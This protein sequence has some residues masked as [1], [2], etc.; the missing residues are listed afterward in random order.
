MVGVESTIV[1]LTNP[2]A[3]ILRA[4]GITKEDLETALGETVYVS[5]GN[6]D[7][8]NSPGQLLKHYAPSKS[9]R[10][11]A[12]VP[13]DDEFYIA[14][15]EVKTRCDLNLSPSSDLREACANLFAF[16]R[17]ADKNSQFTKIAMAPIPE[18]GVGVA[19][20]DRIRRASFK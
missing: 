15:G 4:G 11:N 18:E 1:D 5:D 19:I 7:K 16:M 8:P 20:N 6:P 10:I 12:D 14:F 17:I 9:F 13:S 3:Y 2:K